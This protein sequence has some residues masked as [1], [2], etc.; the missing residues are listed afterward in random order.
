MNTEDQIPEAAAEKLADEAV[1]AGASAPAAASAA[2]GAR[3]HCALNV[4]VALLAAAAAAAVVL[5]AAAFVSVFG[6]SGGG[7]RAQ[8]ADTVTL[9]FGMFSGS[10]WDVANGDS[11]WIID[12]AISRFEAAHPGVR[13]HYYS[14]IRRRDYREW[15]SEQVLAGRMP[16]VAMVLSDQFDSFASKGLLKDL[17][18]VMTRDGRIKNWEYFTTAWDSGMYHGVQY[19]LPYETDFMLMAVNKT[20]LDRHGLPLPE[21]NWTWDDFYALCEKL[22]TDEDNDSVIDTAGVCNYTWQEAVYSNG[23]RLFDRNGR[24]AYFSD[25]KTVQAVQFMQKL[26]DLTA[27]KTF[28]Q[29]DFDAGRVAFMPMSFAAYRTYVSYPYKVIKDLNYEWQCLTMP[30]GYS[31]NNISKVDTLLM[32]ISANTRHEQLAFDLLETLAHD[33]E[34]QKY[35]CLSSQ[36]TSALRMLAASAEARQILDGTEVRARPAMSGLPDTSNGAGVPYVYD[37]GLLADILNKGICAPRFR[38]YDELMIIAGSGISRII[39]DKKDADNSLKLLQRTIQ[40]Q[41]ER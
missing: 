7:Y 2:D 33:K 14:G 9:E 15:C 8:H 26:S 11:Y 6:G 40:T 16:D 27:G 30:A 37:V 39:L 10:N 17:G 29:A 12:K 21:K 20:L 35:V 1:R 28:T 22:T 3:K 34:I 25:Q 24:R 38:R 5:T 19:A 32:G 13:V 18:P 31:G 23:A 4:P 41:L 36:G